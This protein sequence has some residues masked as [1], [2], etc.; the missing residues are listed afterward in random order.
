MANSGDTITRWMDVIQGRKT[1]NLSCGNIKTTGDKLYSYGLHFE[2]ARV[3]RDKK[4]QPERVLLNGDRYG[5]TTTGHQ[6]D[7]RAVVQRSKLPSVTIPHEALRSAG[8]DLDSIQIVDVSRDRTE[9]RKH[10]SATLPEGAKWITEDT[11]A[12]VDLTTE[13][14]DALSAKRNADALEEWERKHAYAVAEGPESYWTRHWVPQNLLPPDP[15]GLSDYD[16]SDWRKTGTRTFLRIGGWTEV[17]V[18]EDGVYRWETS[19]HWLGESL[20]K[21]SIRTSL[22]TVCPSCKGQSTNWRSDDRCTACDGA[23]GKHS[24]RTRTAYFLSG[25]DHAERRPLYF[26]CELP[27]AVRPPKT[28]AEAYQLLKPEAVVLAEGMGRSITR[29]GD[30]FAIQ[31]GAGTTMRSLRKAGATFV[32]RGNLLRTNHEATEVG[33]L[34][35]GTTVARGIMY[36][37]PRGRDPDHGRRRMQDGWHV[38]IKNTVPTTKGKK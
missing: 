4:G 3:L 37:N 26:L 36:H 35:D 12:Y 18:G 27:K 24:V 31:L 13:E 7:V 14:L 10:S 5:N 25:F 30:I 16:R 11:H 34:P 20:V 19:H 21:G 2:L 9:I 28:I 8:I 29:Q 17:E 38:I 33:Y 22:F 1:R 6:N 23:R 15:V 32:K